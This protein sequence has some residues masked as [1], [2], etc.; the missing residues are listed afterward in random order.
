MPEA[1]I[2]DDIQSSAG[3]NYFTACQG[4]LHALFLRPISSQYH[5]VNHD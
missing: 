1:Y 3:P 2:E 4:V 5:D